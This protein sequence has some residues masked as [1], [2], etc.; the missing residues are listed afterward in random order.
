MSGNFQKTSR[1][2][3]RL[4]FRGNNEHWITLML[5]I[6]HM[7]VVRET[8]QTHN[9]HKFSLYAAID[10]KECHTVPCYDTMTVPSWENGM[11]QANVPEVLFKPRLWGNSEHSNIIHCEWGCPAGNLQGRERSIEHYDHRCTCKN[12]KY[13][14]RDGRKSFIPTIAQKKRMVRLMIQSQLREITEIRVFQ[15]FRVSL[16]V[17]SKNSFCLDAC[18]ECN[19]L[20]GI[21]DCLS[22]GFLPAPWLPRL[23]GCIGSVRCGSSG[24]SLTEIRTGVGCWNSQTWL[25][26]TTVICWGGVSIITLW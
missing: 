13:I 12:S 22:V 7:D 5:C 19:D 18:W 6:T 21:Y 2:G 14:C 10:N 11:Q 20:K 1:R 23:G 16:P 4:G 26:P 17:N 15:I 8:P 24:G 9:M 3:R 25:M